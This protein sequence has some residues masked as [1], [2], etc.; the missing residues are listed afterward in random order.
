MNAWQTIRKRLASKPAGAA[1]D[2][3]HLPIGDSNATSSLD[4]YYSPVELQR[5]REGAER[6]AEHAAS[7][8]AA[9]LEK[10]NLRRARRQGRQ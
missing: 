8:L 4:A 6:A 5:L 3:S 9:E 2:W 7:Y 1:E 10:A